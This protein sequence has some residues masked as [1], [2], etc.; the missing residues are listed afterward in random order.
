MLVGYNLV[1]TARAEV[2]HASFVEASVVTA[3]TKDASEPGVGWPCPGDSGVGAD[4]VLGSWAAGFGAVSFPEGHGIPMR[5]GQGLAVQIHYHLHLGQS[6]TPDKTK[7]ELQFARGSVSEARIVGV[8][9]GVEIPPRSVG[10]QSSGSLSL[11]GPG[12]I[13][14]LQPH[15]HLLGKRIGLR[16]MHGDAD[17]CLLDVPN[18]RYHWE[19]LHFLEKGVPFLEGSHVELTCTWDNP[20][21]R[22]VTFGLGLE[23]EM[24]DLAMLVTN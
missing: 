17:T 22:T 11:G 21:D 24:C 4:R 5:K 16:L 13:W 19:Q 10:H 6:A 23:D 9:A 3:T 7:I 12:R 1:P 2:H 18:W 20:A 8:G 14:A 15:M